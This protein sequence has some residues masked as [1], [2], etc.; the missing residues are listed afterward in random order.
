[1]EAFASLGETSIMAGDC[2]AVPWSAAV[3]RVADL[4]KLTVAPSPGPTWLYINLP[5]FLRFAGLPIDQ[6]CSKGSV[7]IHSVSILEGTGS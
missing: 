4:G 5:D 2:N 6:V 7:L 3:R 1:S